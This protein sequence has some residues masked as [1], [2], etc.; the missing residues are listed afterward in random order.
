MSR[1]PYLPT[2]LREEIIHQAQAGHSMQQILKSLQQQGR[3]TSRQT[4][5]RLVK[6]FETHGDVFPLAKVGRPKKLTEETMAEIDR[7]MQ[8]NDET[9]IK[10]MQK[11]F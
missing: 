4:V 8:E 2:K 7:A 11:R 1:R 5:L 6:H 9:T 3:I 10:E